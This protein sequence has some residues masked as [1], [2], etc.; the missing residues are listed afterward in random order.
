M[1]PEA[2][3][4]VIAIPD[5]HAE[6]APAV[7]YPDRDSF[8]GEFRL[9]TGARTGI[10]RIAQTV[11]APIGI[12]HILSLASQVEAIIAI[13][14]ILNIVSD[15]ILGLYQVR[16]AMDR[17]CIQICEFTFY[18]CENI[19][20]AQ[21]IVSKKR[22]ILLFGILLVENAIALIAQIG[23]TDAADAAAAIIEEI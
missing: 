21:I 9:A 4:H 11:G 10:I 13:L 8:V 17:F 15:D 6:R 23:S 16:K 18:A 14:R 7:L 22:L 20:V 12:F 1:H 2:V 3:L 19:A 5:D